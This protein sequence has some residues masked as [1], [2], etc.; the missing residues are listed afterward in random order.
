MLAGAAILVAVGI[1]VLIRTLPNSRR[2]QGVFLQ[3]RTDR[4]SGHISAEERDDLIGMV[5]TAST[6]LHPSGIAVVGS[7]RLDVVSE[8]DFIAKGSR[9]RV[10]RSEGYRHVVEPADSQ[11]LSA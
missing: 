8:G 5:G 2:L 10:I 6:D 1:G 3:A 9:V 4:A 11:A 7:E